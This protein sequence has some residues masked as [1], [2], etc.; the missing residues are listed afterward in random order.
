[1]TQ[2]RSRSIFISVLTLLAICMVSTN[3]LSQA[4]TVRANYQTPKVDQ[5]LLKKQLSEDRLRVYSDFLKVWRRGDIPSL[6]IAM[7]LDAIE[8]SAT[9]E[10]ESCSQSLDTEPMP[11]EP[12]HQFTLSDASKLGQGFVSLVDR[13]AQLKAVE[14]FDPWNTIQHGADV[15]AAVRN[16]FSHGLFSFSEIQFDKTHEHAILTYS[17]YCG[18]ECGNGGTVV[19]TRSEIGTWTI[20]SRCHQWIG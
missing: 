15:D 4:Q 6:N 12:L 17:F 16:G 14:S 18:R 9:S 20:T 13:D 19:L 8:P 10:E 5:K 3:L 2:A 11:K 1:M 7:D